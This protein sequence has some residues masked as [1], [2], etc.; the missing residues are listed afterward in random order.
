[1]L[2]MIHNFFNNNILDE[3]VLFHCFDNLFPVNRLEGKER[4]GLQIVW[5]AWI[6]LTSLSGDNKVYMM[7]ED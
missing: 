3:I 1:M 2:L 5:N 7:T 6:K 4:I